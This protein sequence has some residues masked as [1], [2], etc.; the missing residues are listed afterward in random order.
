MFLEFWHFFIFEVRKKLGSR[1]AA[2]TCK[3]GRRNETAS[4]AWHGE[5][6]SLAFHRPSPLVSHTRHP[7]LAN[8]HASFSSRL[9]CALV[10]EA[11]ADHICPPE[12]PLL[13]S[14]RALSTQHTLS[15][16]S[17]VSF[18]RW[19]QGPGLVYSLLTAAPRH[20][21]CLFWTKG[22]GR[23]KRCSITGYTMIWCR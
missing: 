7:H 19:Q 10:E 22:R 9:R 4:H 23:G 15:S 8:V 14:I 12:H 21:G 3:V 1:P 20:G 18:P 5:P 16:S 2:L 17:F 13:S 6:P 11:F